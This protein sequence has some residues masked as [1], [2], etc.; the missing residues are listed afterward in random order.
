MADWE[1]IKNNKGNKCNRIS[2]CIT[3]IYM[4]TL[5]AKK[6]QI[7]IWNILTNISF[8]FYIVNLSLVI[9]LWFNNTKPGS[10]KAT[11]HMM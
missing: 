1:E 5:D 7:I 6:F 2:R 9:C 3:I 11:K 8:Q 10:D 4:I